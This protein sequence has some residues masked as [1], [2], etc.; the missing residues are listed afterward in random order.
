MTVKRVTVF[1]FLFIVVFTFAL[2]HSANTCA[3]VDKYFLC[4][5]MDLDV[6]VL[7]FICL[8]RLEDCVC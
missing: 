2:F 6:L 7:C 3:P 1:T 8:G 5:S 4:L